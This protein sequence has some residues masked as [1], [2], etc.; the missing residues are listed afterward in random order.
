[1]NSCA[2]NVTSDTL[3]LDMCMEYASIIFLVHMQHNADQRAD[4]QG[5]A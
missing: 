3:L 5:H 2:V 4:A 1:M